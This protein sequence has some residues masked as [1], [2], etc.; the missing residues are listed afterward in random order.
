[1]LDGAY[2]LNLARGVHVNE[3]ELSGI[4]GQRQG[5]RCHAGCLHSEPLPESPLWKY[6][7][8]AMTPHSPQ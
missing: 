5:E 2:V 8:V 6:P 1:M 3:D 7:R 4:A